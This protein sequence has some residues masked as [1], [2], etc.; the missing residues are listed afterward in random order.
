[1]SESSVTSTGRDAVPT[2]H[3]AA[4]PVLLY[5]E[6]CS[7]CRRFISLV[8]N[9]DNRGGMRIAP[10]LS[11]L[12]DAI[13]QSHPEYSA[14][15]SALWIGRDGNILAYSDAILAALDYLGGPWTALTAAMRIVPHALRDAAY[16]TFASNRNLFAPLGLSELDSRSLGRLLTN[17]KSRSVEQ[18][19]RGSVGGASAA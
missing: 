16:R 17:P 9:A 6:N 8:V 18:T 13:R 7:V 4:D 19:A 1:M 15:D 3:N 2:G 10:L 5:D 12:G 14:R 11:P